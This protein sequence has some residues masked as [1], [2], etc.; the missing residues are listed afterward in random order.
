MTLAQRGVPGNGPSSIRFQPI[1]TPKNGRSGDLVVSTAFETTWKGTSYQHLILSPPRQWNGDQ[2][3]ELQHPNKNQELNPNQ[4]ISQN[5][6]LN[7]PTTRFIHINSLHFICH[8]WEWFPSFLTISALKF[9]TMILKYTE[10]ITS[11]PWFKNG[12]PMVFS[13]QTHRNKL[14]APSAK[15]HCTLVQL[16]GPLHFKHVPP[17]TSPQG[18]SQLCRSPRNPSK[19]CRG[20]SE[21]NWTVREVQEWEV[22]DSFKWEMTWKIGW[23]GSFLSPIMGYPN[24]L[25]WVWG[26]FHSKFIEAKDV[27]MDSAFGSF[28]LIP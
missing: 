26:R 1:P 11:S 22:R 3:I 5:S 23:F 21:G 13:H 27:Y 18:A 4:P 28:I 25:R 20:D 15:W 2:L 9:P 6:N 16:V 8:F 17:K 10:I 12:T 7:F 19:R 24:Y 14:K